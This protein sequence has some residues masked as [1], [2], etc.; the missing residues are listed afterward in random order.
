MVSKQKILST[1]KNKISFIRDNYNKMSTNKMLELFQSLL[2]YMNRFRNCDLGI[3]FDEE[4]YEILNKK[5]SKQKKINIKRKNKN[6]IK[7]AYL[8]SKFSDIGGASLSKRFIL[9]SYKYNNFNIEN[10]IILVPLD[11]KNS[12][13]YK[14]TSEYNHASKVGKVKLIDDN[15]NFFERSKELSQYLIKENIEIAI[16]DQNII[17]IYTLLRTKTQVVASLSQDI[18]TYTFGPGCFDINFYLSHDQLFKY[19]FKEDNKTINKII[20]L[21]LPKYNYIKN[22][23]KLNKSIFKI[24]KNST[25]SAS[26][27]LWK[28][29]FGDS[30]LFITAIRKLIEKN[31]NH[32]HFFIGS[33]RCL[34]NLD[35]Y[36]SQHPL[37]KNNVHFVGEVKNIY[38]FLKMIDFWINSFPTSGGS[39]LEA[40][41]VGKPSIEWVHNR[42]LTLHPVEFLNSNECN[43]FNLNEFINLGNKLI[44]DKKYRND[45]GKIL[46]KRVLLD[47]NHEKI[48]KEKIN[49][50]LIDALLDK[51]NSNLVNHNI[52]LINDIEY[53]KNIAYF[54]AHFKHNS[55]SNKKLQYLKSLMKKF[56]NKY[57]GY[58]KYLEVIID[59]NNYINVNNFYKNLNLNIKND[60]RVLLLI[61]VYLLKKNNLSQ[62]EKF[63]NL[64]LNLTEY[65]IMPYKILNDIYI[66]QNE[67]RKSFNLVKKI[68][69]LKNINL[70]EIKLSYDYY[71]Y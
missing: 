18:Y 5:I 37:I 40:A 34:D 43:V 45:L 25:I 3:Y 11:F 49:N 62:S 17:S 6:V 54:N 70:N 30:D 53:E 10:H 55:S 50:F 51:K 66:K 26:S 8:K 61:S 71:D 21:P 64:S 12:K 13:L 31:K 46:K 29:F 36:L 23:K 69:E 68:N 57:F 56:P 52:E 33:N 67:I 19:K 59:S 9:E 15:K 20:Y 47:F 65:D 22:S 4:V 58:V 1:Y 28:C 38:R 32:H 63:I 44:R 27:N 7:I 16:V 2:I 41:A 24:P 48:I 39:D 42:N 35:I 60:Y 14:K